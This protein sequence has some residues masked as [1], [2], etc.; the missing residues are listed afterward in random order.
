MFQP[1]TS[2]RSCEDDPEGQS[3]CLAELQV[4]QGSTGFYRVLQEPITAGL[5]MKS[6]S[7]TFRRSFS[8]MNPAGSQQRE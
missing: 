5:M 6:D 8:Q 4:L 7:V 2:R 3:C 1:G